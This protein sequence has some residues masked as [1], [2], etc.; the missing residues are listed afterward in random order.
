MHSTDDG[1]L[2]NFLWDRGRRN[3]CLNVIHLHGVIPGSQLENNT[4]ELFIIVRSSQATF[5]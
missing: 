4:A 5:L 3:L 2:F 1:F